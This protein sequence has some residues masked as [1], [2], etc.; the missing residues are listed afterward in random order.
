MI[1]ERCSCGAEFETDEDNPVKLLTTWRKLH[2]H[3]PPA[4]QHDS[5]LTV[6]TE[7]ISQD[8][9]PRTTIGFT[10]DPWEDK[11]GITR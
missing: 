2:R 5:D 8:T 6:T 3:E 4:P 1:R 10:T 7:T 9:T 11:N